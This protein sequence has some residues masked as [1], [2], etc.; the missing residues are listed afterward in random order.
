MQFQISYKSSSEF[1]L[2]TFLYRSVSELDIINLHQACIKV[3]FSIAL[4]P[5]ILGMASASGHI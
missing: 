1:E 4:S 2:K 5:N 3:F